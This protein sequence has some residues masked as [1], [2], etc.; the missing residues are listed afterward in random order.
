MRDQQPWL[1]CSHEESCR[2][3]LCPAVFRMQ[4]TFCCIVPPLKTPFFPPPPKTTLLLPRQIPATYL[5]VC[6]YYLGVSTC[7][8]KELKPETLYFQCW[9]VLTLPTLLSMIVEYT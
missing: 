7:N 5:L 3:S 6:T 9:L 8:K 1:L 2:I 4:L